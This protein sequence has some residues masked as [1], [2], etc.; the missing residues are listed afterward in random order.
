MKKLIK[1]LEA[2]VLSFIESKED[3]LIAV[4]CCTQIIL[5]VVAAIL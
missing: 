1:K 2:T 3:V 5:F 4:L